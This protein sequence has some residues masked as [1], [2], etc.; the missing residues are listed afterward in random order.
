MTG[1]N[2]ARTNLWDITAVAPEIAFLA[3]DE[4]L[5]RKGRRQLAGCFPDGRLHALRRER[6]AGHRAGDKMR[7]VE[8]RFAAGRPIAWPAAPATSATSAAA[9]GQEETRGLPRSC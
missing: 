1:S 8:D 6:V 5:G 4:L 3:V 9:G 2:A 7:R